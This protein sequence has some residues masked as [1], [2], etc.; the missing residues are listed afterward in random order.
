MSNTK[1]NLLKAFA[2][3]C[4]A[5]MRYE[6]A[7]AIAKQQKLPII[8]RLFKFTAEQEKEHAEIFYNHLKQVFNEETVSIEASY[9]IDINDDL[10]YLLGQAEIH[11]NDEAEVIYKSFGDEAKNE[12][13]Q[14]VATSFYMISDIEKFHHERFKKYKELLSCGKLFIGE[15]SQQWMCLNCGFI[16]EGN[17]APENCPVCKHEQGYFI[18]IQEA[19]FSK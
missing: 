5:R 3:E 15:N 8:E 2:G 9:P 11:E 7:A 1:N 10:V 13:L 14:Q 18:K 12:G 17:L 6:L 19:P 4:Q 16:Y